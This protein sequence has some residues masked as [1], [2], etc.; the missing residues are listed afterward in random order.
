MRRVLLLA[1]LLAGCKEL[2]GSFGDVI[3]VEVLG[4][5]TRTVEEGDTLRLA[6]RAL[7]RNGDTVAA[8]I[9]WTV[10][11]TAVG[12]TLDT[13]SG[14]VSAVTPGGP[15]RVVPR[16]GDLRGQT[17]SLLVSGAADSIAPVSD[18]SVMALGT[19]NSS[20]IAVKVFDLTT[21]PGTQIALN[22]TQV[23]F[24]VI[25]PAGTGLLL[26]SAA[27]P[28][29]VATA[30]TTT[31][32]SAGGGT[33]TAVLRAG[34]TVPDSAIVEATAMTAT[35]GAVAGSPIRFVVRYQ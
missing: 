1:L 30:D 35:G 14:L 34:G 8:T 24:T 27:D 4:S 21:S 31:I 17:I 2:T 5:A 10:L 16:A 3:A 15:W 11:D 19:D 18:T 7:D 6:A 28:D 25:M 9:T 12:F 23:H 32:R 33:A 13:A 20:P 26:R 29:S 22:G